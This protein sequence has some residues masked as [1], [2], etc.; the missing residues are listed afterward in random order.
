M[1]EFP[2]KNFML[3]SILRITQ[4]DITHI[5]ETLKLSLGYLCIDKAVFFR[6]LQV[7]IPGI[8]SPEK[9]SSFSLSVNKTS[10]KDSNFALND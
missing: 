10:P 4:Y 5:N 6:I 3:T 8:L 7:D 2:Y 1:P 9:V